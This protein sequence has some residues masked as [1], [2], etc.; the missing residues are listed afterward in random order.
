MRGETAAALISL[1]VLLGCGRA[2]EPVDAGVQ[3]APV[4]HLEFTKG[5]VTLT[6]DGA[7]APAQLGYLYTRDTL[8]T[9]SDGEAKLRFSGGRDLQMGP[10]SRFVL[11]EDAKGLVLQVTL[12]SLV[13]QMGGAGE[14]DLKALSI[15]TPFGSTQLGTGRNGVSLNVG[16]EGAKV[17]VLAGQVELLD[18]SGQRQG[19]AKGGSIELTLGKLARVEQGPPGVM[20]LAS[21]EVVVTDTGV[22][23]VRHKGQ[24]RWVALKRGQVLLPG[25]AVRVRQGRST[26]KL[27][28]STVGI[29]PGAE[30][31]FDS[32]KRDGAVDTSTVELTKGGLSLTLA[33][34]KR[35]RVNVSGVQLE[36]KNGGQ[37]A[38]YKTQDGLEVSAQAGD[39]TAKKGDAE[40][41]VLAGQTAH[42]GTRNNEV[43]NSGVSEITLPSRAG[44]KVFHSGSMGEVTLTWPGEKRDYWVE[45]G[46]DPELNQKLLRGVVHQSFVTVEAPRQG[47]LYWRVM[48]A[49]GKTALDRGSAV[50]RPEL[51]ASA[52]STFHD[53]VQEGSDRTTIYY[54]NA[55]PAVT[56]A[57]R[58][59]PNAAR[60]H[61][62]VYKAADVS[63]P[64]AAP[65]VNKTSTNERIVLEA[66]SLPEGSYVWS[67]TPQSDKGEALR[68]GKMTKLDIVYDNAIPSLVVRSPKAGDVVAGNRVQ[69]TGVATV[70]S[71]VL[72]NGKPGA[73]DDKGRFDEPVTPVGRSPVVVFRLVRPNAVDVVL[74]RSLR[75]GAH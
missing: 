14:G 42:L 56:L 24:R 1:A 71:K 69:A 51:S 40:Q 8:Q 34:G 16:K 52:A 6:R 17:E 32:A 19:L 61:V 15:Q 48:E 46:L 70:G 49:D 28:D 67:A 57:Y 47:A 62:E 60:Y 30:M 54:Q 10:D 36:S 9:G 4:A 63:T 12:G 74:V 59:E 33:E 29:S 43:H 64:G 2:P 50:F 25:D 3:R 65:L 22:A 7:D 18:N 37:F 31:A 27:A 38:L 72:I 35:T 53:T 23:E 5:T 41:P 66:G 58:A 39:V 11:D 20:E 26:V 45:V 55:L 75:R 13:A 44:T 21:I 68:G 73:L